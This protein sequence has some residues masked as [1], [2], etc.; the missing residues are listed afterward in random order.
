MS[1]QKLTPWLPGEVKPSRPGVYQQFCGLGSEI[2]YQYWDGKIWYTWA[3]TRAG[4]LREYEHGWKSCYQNDK[5]RGL[6]IAPRE[7]QA[8]VECPACGVTYYVKGGYKPTYMAALDE[9]DL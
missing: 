5:W 6:A 7:E 9:D 1:E 8:T 4:A 2:G 3:K